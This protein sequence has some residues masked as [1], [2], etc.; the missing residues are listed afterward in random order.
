M[1]GCQFCPFSKESNEV[2][3]VQGLDRFCG[4]RFVPLGCMIVSVVYFGS[5]T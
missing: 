5:A 4:V 3:N 1:N 2:N